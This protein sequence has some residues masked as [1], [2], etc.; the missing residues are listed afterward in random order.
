MLLFAGPLAAH[1]WLDRDPRD[2]LLFDARAALGSWIGWRNYVVGPATEELTFRSHILAL[3][4]AMAPSTATPTV[5]T[6]CT[7]LYFG[8][9]H[10][11]HLYEFRLTHPSAPLHLAVVRSL[12]QFAYTTL[13]GWYAAFIYLRFGSLWAAI[14]AHSFCNVMG[15]PRFW[16]VL[17]AEPHGRATWRTW[18]YYLLLAVG[19]LGFYTCLWSWTG[20][21]N[22]LVQYT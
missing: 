17:D 8:I 9:A 14:A 2:D 15:L 6:L 11:H 4:L 18:T 13:F 3:H 16:G 12:V 21:R 5:L 20:S 10:L 7:P 22:A 19:A 1:L